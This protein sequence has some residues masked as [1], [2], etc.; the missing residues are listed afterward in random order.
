MKKILLLLLIILTVSGCGTSGNEK[1]ANENSAD[2]NSADKNSVKVGTL[3]QLNTA[4]KDA[5]TVEGGKINFYDNFNS[6]QMALKSKQIDKM[7]TYQSVAKYLT[8]NNS[9]FAIDD[10]QR[11]VT[12]VDNFCCAMRAKDVELKNSFDAAINSMKKDG[13][14]ATLTETFIDK[15]TLKPTAVSMPKFDDADTIRVG[16]TGDLPPLDLILADG[17]PAGFNTA[18]LA[19]ISNRIGENIELVQIDSAARAVALTSGKVDVIFWVVVPEDQNRPKDFDTPEGV[20][21]TD[22]YY[23]DYV[24]HVN[25]SNLGAG[26]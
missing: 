24:V 7:Q 3:T 16:I 1:S 5:A 11:T 22:S 25:L 14:L 15:P 18:V 12:L 17:T 6:M 19:E 2:K 10:S 9:D 4:P 20:A 8:G 26:F 13:T 23:Q 21:V